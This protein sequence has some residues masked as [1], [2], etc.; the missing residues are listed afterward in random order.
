MQF[1]LGTSGYSYPD[2][3]GGFYPPGTRPAGMLA[4]YVRH[5]PL[6]ELN[7]TFYRLPTPA[8]L[9]RLADQTPPGF[10]FVVKL[11]RTLS[12]DEDPRDLPPFR[13]AVEELRVRDRLLGLLGQLPQSTHDTERHRG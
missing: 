10:Q 4:H 12:H 6:V 11:P 7:F 1:W 5:F 8:M 3:V 2:W 9:A 13:L